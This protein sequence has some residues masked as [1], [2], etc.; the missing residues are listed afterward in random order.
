MFKYPGTEIYNQQGAY[1]VVFSVEE[2]DLMLSEGWFA[3]NPVPLTDMLREVAEVVSIEKPKRGRKAV[4][5]S[6]EPDAA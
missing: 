1:R 3:D 6:T 2:Y 5:Q 4:V